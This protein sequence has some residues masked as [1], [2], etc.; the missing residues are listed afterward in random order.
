MDLKQIFIFNL[1]KFRNN[2]GLSQMKLAEMCDTATNYIGEIEIGRRFPSLKLIEKIGQVLEV[3]PY[4][5]FIGKSDKGQ[6]ELDETND[7]FANLPDKE[8]LG[9]INRI[10][11]P[12]EQTKYLP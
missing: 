4:R 3:E 12:S 1:R 8:R 6:T 11:R 7:F 9:I 2:K 5:F 10:S